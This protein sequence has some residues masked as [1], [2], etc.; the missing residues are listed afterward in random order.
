MKYFQNKSESNSSFATNSIY[1]LNHKNQSNC[2]SI[3]KIRVNDTSLSNDSDYLT[4]YRVNQPVQNKRTKVTKVSSSDYSREDRQRDN[5]D[6]I[7]KVLK[8]STRLLEKKYQRDKY[9]LIVYDDWKEVASRLDL[10]LFL[11]ASSIV[12]MTPVLLFGKFIIR[13]ESFSSF[14]STC[15]RDFNR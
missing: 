11:L 13:D 12:I 2:K 9:N 14:N 4:S 1:A 15:G 3:E 10:V 6:K 5:L 7:L 8:R